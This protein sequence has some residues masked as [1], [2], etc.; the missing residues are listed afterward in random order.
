MCVTLSRGD[1]NPGSYSPYLTSSYTTIAPIVYDVVV[2]DWN[3]IH[4]D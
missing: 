1:L 4:K 2:N 3:T